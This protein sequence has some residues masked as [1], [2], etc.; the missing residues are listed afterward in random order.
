MRQAKAFL[1]VCAGIFLLA[2]AYHLGARS[3][4]A[5]VGG[6]LLTAGECVDYDKT[7]ACVDRTLYL[8]WA[9]DPVTTY[10]SVPGTAPVI[11]VGYQNHQVLAML[12][13]GDTYRCTYNTG[14]PWEFICNAVSGPGPVPAQGISIGQLKAEYATP[15]K[16]TR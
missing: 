10:P 14:G 16:D 11:A 15:A 7:V 12:S 6:G 3:A 2:L 8:T 4:G 9:S 5:Q 13:N 1:V